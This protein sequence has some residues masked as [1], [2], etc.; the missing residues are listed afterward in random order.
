MPQ[1]GILE[2]HI[3]INGRRFTLETGR[4]A[5]QANGA[6]L[7]KYGD[8]IVLV[9][10]TC[11]DAREGIDFFPLMV[12]YEERHYAVGRIPGSFMKREG[13]PGEKAILSAR[14]IDRSIRPLFP[15]NFRKD[16]HVVAMVMSVD[17]DCSPTLAAM[18]GAS[19]ALHLSDIP[20]QGPIGS[21]IIGY[22]NGELVVNPNLEQTENSKLHLTLAGTRD[23]VNMVEAGADEIPEEIILDGVA[24][25]HEII[26]KIVSGIE[27]M[28]E[29]A[30]ALGLAKPK[31]EVPEEE[32]N[33]DLASSVEDLAREK[34]KAA[35]DYCAAT[36]LDKKS[37]EVYL[38]SVKDEIIQAFIEDYPDDEATIKAVVDKVEK[39]TLRKIITKEKRRID[40]RALDEIRPITVEAGILPRTH[41]SGLFQRG[42]TQVLSV[43]T[44]GPISDVQILDNLDVEESKRYLHHYN[45]PSFSTGETKPIRAPGRREIGHGALAERALE[46]VIPP[47][48]DF[49]YTIRIVSEVLSSNGSTSMASVCGSTLA[50]MDAGIPIKA[51]VAGI[52]MGLIKEEDE[53]MILTDI[54]GIEDHLGDMDFKV[55]GTS[56][57]ITALQMDIKIAG[58]TKEILSRALAQAKKARLYILEKIRELLPQPRPDLSPL[59]P[60]VLHTNID[61]DKI[62]DVIGPGGKTIRKITEE[63]GV[64]IDIEDDGR[65]YIT[66]PN[67]ESAQRALD[68][69]EKITGDVEIGKVYLGKVTRITEFGA[70][71]EVIPGVMGLPGKEGLVHISQLAYSHV[72]RVEDVVKEGDQILVKAIGYDS[73][74]RLKLSKKE[75]MDPPEGYEKK[76]HHPPRRHTN[77]RQARKLHGSR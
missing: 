1:Q 61:P 49:P 57:G 8:T 10:A 27:E 19:A 71:V 38:D 36:K 43:V 72:R 32:L 20:F 52:A 14:L 2:K 47:E 21:C 48:E 68:V 42:Q 29:E 4:V 53:F 69:I 31:M 58:I 33:E 70:F 9:T 15:K 30:L 73:Q 45:F 39:E 44:L 59:A 5:G 41:G 35:M 60:R 77:P 76:E 34:L 63:T 28:R 65:V 37:R 55:A 6:V 12:D 46:P 40:G 17:Q 11:A 26:K 18:I 24:L 62:K 74:G 3:D 13:R 56:Q 67:V 16:V 66:A 7:A 54:Q 51:P 22:V 64:D 75:A 25:G 50:L 23:A